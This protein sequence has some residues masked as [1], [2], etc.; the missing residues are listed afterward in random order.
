MKQDI[1]PEPLFSSEI[2]GLKDLQDLIVVEE[3]DERFLV[4]L[5]GEV[6]D[7]L[8]RL[9][10]IGVHKADHLSKGFQGGESMIAG[11]GEVF[12]LSL[13]IVEKGQDEPGGDVFQPEGSDLDPVVLCSEG[14]KELEGI[15]VGFDGMGAD[16]FDVGKILAEE[17]MDKGVELHRIFCC[18]REKSTR[19]LR[20]MASATLR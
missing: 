12:S 11:P 4:A 9:S 7:H 19:F 10:L 14:Q 13:E 15:P 2:D 3:S 16:P 5:L 6:E 8:C 18:Q 20:L 17:L 1:V